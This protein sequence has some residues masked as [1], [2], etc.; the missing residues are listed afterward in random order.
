MDLQKPWMSL[1]SVFGDCMDELKIELVEN[2]TIYAPGERV[3]GKVSWNLEKFPR[4]A[5]VRL[6]WYTQGRGT[7]DA[8][9]AVS[10]TFEGAG[11][12]DM[13]KFD[14]VLPE[15]PLSF[16]G[17]LITLKWALELSIE[18][19]NRTEREEIVLTTQGKAIE[20]AAVK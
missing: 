20:L 19:G 2:R 11:Q 12:R 9:L 6:V 17:Q 4:K 8:G 10:K 7:A 18:P 3:S 14:F 16:N 1:F 13:R 5:E 15:G